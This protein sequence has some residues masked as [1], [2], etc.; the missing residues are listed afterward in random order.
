MAIAISAVGG[1]VGSLLVLGADAERESLG[2]V[3]EPLS[4]T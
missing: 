1:A 2:D 4:A 3:A